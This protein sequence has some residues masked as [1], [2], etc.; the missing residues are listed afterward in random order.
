V[1]SFHVICSEVERIVSQS[2][3]RRDP[4][5]DLETH[6]EHPAPGDRLMMWLLKY[7][8]CLACVYF[9]HFPFVISDVGA[10]LPRS[11]GCRFQDT[12]VQR[13]VDV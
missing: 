10:A 1:Q 3:L 11:G 4:E 2:D 5:P 8:P 9:P 7:L 6:L 12:A 13:K